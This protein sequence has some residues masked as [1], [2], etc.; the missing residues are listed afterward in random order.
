ME[1]QKKIK[2][3]GN[4]KTERDL[5]IIALDNEINSLEAATNKAEYIMQDVCENY[6]ERYDPQKNAFE[7]AN[8]FQRHYAKA[9][10]AYDYI[11]KIG[12]I[13]KSLAKPANGK[14]VKED[15]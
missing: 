13:I 15:A 4:Q 12:L 11:H 9:E 1:S 7:I 3:S 5:A 6:F 14:E 10:I 2:P 8:E